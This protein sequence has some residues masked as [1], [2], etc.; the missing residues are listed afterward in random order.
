[1]QVY[2]GGSVWRGPKCTCGPGGH[3]DRQWLLEGMVFVAWILGTTSGVSGNFVYFRAPAEGVGE[4]WGGLDDEG[5]VRWQEKVPIKYDHKE[6]WNLK[7]RILEQLT[8]LYDCQQ[9]EIMEL[10]TGM[11]SF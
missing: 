3:S 4:N 11:M 2:S 9:E 1:M 5:P 8:H 7:E 6:L 10:E